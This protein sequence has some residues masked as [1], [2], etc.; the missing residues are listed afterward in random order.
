MTT[1]IQDKRELVQTLADLAEAQS[2]LAKTLL[3]I[4]TRES[5][6]MAESYAEAANKSADRALKHQHELAQ[7][8]L[9]H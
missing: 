4:D 5:I 2:M 7:L 9:K 6:Y 3:R 1:H 8:K